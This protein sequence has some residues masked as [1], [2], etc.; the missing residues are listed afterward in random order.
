M[1]SVPDSSQEAL[2]FEPFAPPSTA[3]LNRLI[4]AYQF[5]EFIDRGGMGAV[6]KAVQRSLNRTVAVKLLPQVHRDKETFAER[7]KREAHALAQLNHPHIVAV[8]DFGETPDGQMYY[9][10]EYVSGMDL[11]HLLKRTSPE[12]RQLLKII[13][14]VCQALQFAHERGIVH[15]DVKPANILIDERGNVKVA[16]FGLAKVVGPTSV[17][18][19]ATGTTLGTPDYIAPEAMEQSGKVDHRA[20]IYSLG[21]M[22]YELLTGHVP[23]GMWEPPSIRSG[24]DRRVDVL[25]S[26]AMQNDPDK[27]YQHVSD[28]TQVLEKLLLSAD[29]WK[30]Y[31]RP[32][33]SEVSGGISNGPVSTGAETVNIKQRQRRRSGARMAVV[34][35][36]LLSG[37]AATAAWKAGWLGQ[38]DLAAEQ[39]DGDRPAPTKT[40]TATVAEQEQLAQWVFAHDGFVNVVTPSSPDHL[41]GEEADIWYSV[42]LPDEPYTVWRVCFSAA[43]IK[44]EVMLEDLLRLIRYAG[45]VSNL[46][47]RGLD[48]P[49]EALAPL[50]QIETIINLDLTASAIVSHDIAPYL[51]ACPSLRVVRVSNNKLPANSTLIEHMA[52]LLPT[53]RISTTD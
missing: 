42:D 52:M 8:Y 13:T 12:P 23:K 16:D 4:P 53:C 14:Q 3:E 40:R 17:D 26:K 24:A 21:V 49:P 38:P 34:A 50:A 6:Y 22:I 9:A 39:A 32:A 11:Q 27:R 36:A 2:R 25:V 45:T 44:D 7:F 33:R 46:S 1:S 20:D 35:L 51:A 47:L 41:M 19:T 48:V 29:A 37:I 30:N 43:P 15:R 31:R 10:M 5:L 28:M 18:Y